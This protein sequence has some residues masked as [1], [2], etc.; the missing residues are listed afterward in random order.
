MDYHQGKERS[1][2]LKRAFEA[3]NDDRSR[4]TLSG[5]NLNGPLRRPKFN[6]VKV[7]GFCLTNQICDTS[8]KGVLM[9]TTTSGRSSGKTTTDPILV[10]DSYARGIS[11]GRVDPQEKKL[12]LQVDGERKEGE[13]ML[14]SRYVMRSGQPLQ[15][16]ERN[17]ARLSARGE[18]RRTTIVFGVTTD[19]FHPF[20]EKF[21]TSMKFLEIFERYSPGRLVIQTRSPLVV[22]GL[23][24]LK[25]VRASTCIAIGIETPND[26]IRQ[27]Y[28]PEL[29][30]VTERWKTVRALRRFGLTVGVQVSPML[31]YGDW[32]ADAGAFADELCEEADFITVRSITQATGT[33]RPNTPI[34]RKLIA[35]RQFFWLRH[36]THRHLEQAIAR[37]AEGKLLHP[38]DVDIPDPQ[39]ALFGTD[40][41]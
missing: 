24:L 28:T 22:I 7:T 20:D 36:D 25:K 12:G 2:S 14:R 11:I 27:R 1:K 41:S 6:R 32:R 4:L 35:D 39:I 40:P 17:L 33:A 13:A 30:S 15:D 26:A 31:P 34:A 18:L 16:L 38:V 23:P 19:P 21:A 37:R 29:P 9:N 8:K 10:V 5:L 3:T